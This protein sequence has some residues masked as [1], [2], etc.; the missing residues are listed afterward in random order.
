LI[1]KLQHQNSRLSVQVESFD[2]A[3]QL[4]MSLQE[5]NKQIGSLVSQKRKLE[6]QIKEITKE[7]VD[8]HEA[9]KDQDTLR[10]VWTFLTTL[11]MNHR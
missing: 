8:L 1:Q 7:N 5:E 2:D 10:N 3:S 6:E 9:L 11:L 4:A